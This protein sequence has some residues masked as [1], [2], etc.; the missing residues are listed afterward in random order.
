MR[1]ISNLL[2]S[3]SASSRYHSLSKTFK[4]LLRAT[5]GLLPDLVALD[6]AP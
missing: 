3:D 5:A 1:D 2:E 4:R 6:P